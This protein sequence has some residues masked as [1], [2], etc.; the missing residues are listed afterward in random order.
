M[1][2]NGVHS[3]A[4]MGVST[5]L[6]NR[7]VQ[8]DFVLAESGSLSTVFDEFIAQVIEVGFEILNQLLM[9]V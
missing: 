4:C 6:Q 9:I 8:S 5:I 1:I 3:T 2:F 7:V